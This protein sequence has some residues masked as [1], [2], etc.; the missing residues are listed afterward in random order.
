M[1]Q[2][3][4]ILFI[5]AFCIFTILGCANRGG[6]PQGGPKDT[7]PP[8]LLKCSPENGSTNV[9]S[10]KIQ[11]TFDEIVLVQSTF[12]KV[13]IS[14][15]QSQMA[16]IKASGHKVNV[17][18]QDS[19]KES[20]T[21][22]IDFTNSI[23]DN[24]E[25]NELNGFTF[26]FATGD[27][28]DTLKI[29][30]T[31]VDAQTLNPVPN[32]LVGIHSNLGDSAFLSKPFDRIAKTDDKGK[33]TINNVKAGEYHIFA[34][35]D[36]G[37]NYYF[38]I[39]TEQ[40]AF[41]DSI[42]TPNCTTDITYDTI[43]HYA[44]IDSVNNIVDSTQLIIDSITTKYNYIYTPD[45]V[46][47]F[48]FTETT[49]RL[50]LT[51]S[52]RKERHQ[53][54][55]EFANKCDSLPIIK[56]LNVAD[57]LFT[58]L[59]QTSINQD[60][61]T[62]WLTDTLLWQ[63]DTIKLETTYIK[64]DDSTYWHTD[65]ITFIYREPRNSKS[66]NKNEPEADL[67]HTLSTNKST[68]F[69]IYMP[70]VLT[71]K[72]PTTLALNDSVGYRL[73]E[74]VD[75]NWIDLP[76]EITK[77]DSIGLKYQVM[78]QWKPTTEYQLIIDSTLFTSFIGKT[79]NHETISFRTK[80]LEEYSIL[81]IELTQHTGKEVI[82][83]LDKNDAI[84]KELHATDPKVRFEYMKP[85]T[86]YVRLFIDENSN[87]KWDAG[88]YR[89]HSQAEKVYYYPY[90]IELRAF[91]DVEEIWNYTELPILEQKPKELVKTEKK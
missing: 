41:D 22:T 54:T 58:Y 70:L 77:I 33:F 32:L 8:K 21:Y 83:I 34:L 64:R 48:A 84:V 2:T 65:T 18:L 86:Y 20:T 15:P 9:S 51:K 62:Y 29:S 50:Y 89:Q 66:K 79:T 26:S 11:L 80:S 7:T 38:D 78:H 72:Q 52:E 71:F 85:D 53:L 6:G 23:V 61:I 90:D 19:L 60:T 1:K 3:I 81:I 91:W 27:F 30:G 35:S 73:Q 59:Q 49:D 44:I 28:I 36:I 43:S 4:N 82:Q 69:D 56:P 25:R 68:S 47:L 17:E 63:Q 10:N 5:I 16:I 31:I 76:A 74:K 46:V 87:G 39:P 67:H 42:Y 55:L 37:S 14:P 88:N 40:I 45:D 12:E 13:I 75:T 57:S 24:N